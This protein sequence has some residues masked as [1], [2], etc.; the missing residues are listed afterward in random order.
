MAVLKFQAAR[1]LVIERVRA[2]RRSPR[3]ET[4]PLLAAQGRVL[5]APVIADRDAPPFNRST[6]DGYAVRSSDV[7]NVPS[8]LKLIGRARA[9]VSFDGAVGQ[10]ECVEI[11]TG[12]PLPAGA[13]AVVMVEYTR[14]DDGAILVEHRVGA[15]ENVVARGSESRAG[16]TLLQP[17]LRLQ[18]AELAM[19]AAVDRKS[20]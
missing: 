11:M 7:V 2:A 4:V 3:I 17:G 14:S 16:D 5:A 6:R 15:N 12:A 13:D 19:A 8:H 20:T 10:G 9:G 1:E 18:Y